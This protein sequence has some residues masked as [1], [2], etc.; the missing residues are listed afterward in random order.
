MLIVGDRGVILQVKSRDPSSDGDPEKLRRWAAKKTAEAGRQVLG[1]RRTLESTTLSLRS[2]RGHE[3]SLE[4]P[5]SWPGVILLDL[6]PVP[7]G[8]RV[9]GAD[10]NTIIMTLSDW[11]ALHDRIRSTSGV[12]DYIERVA[13]HNVEAD[14]GDEWTRYEQFAAADARHASEPGYVPVLP[15]KSLSGIDLL[16]VDIVD[17]WIDSDI[18]LT[19]VKKSPYTA[20]QVRSTIEL[21]DAIPILLRASIGKKLLGA[22]RESTRTREPQSGY[23][24]TGSNGRLLYFVDVID[25]WKGREQSLEL[26]LASYA[27]VRHEQLENLH[28]VGTTLMLARISTGG[29]SSIRTYAS[30]S[31]RAEGLNITPEV[32]W[33]TN[34]RYHVL[35]GDVLRDPLSYGRNEQCACGS[36]KRF[37]HCHLQQRQSSKASEYSNGAQ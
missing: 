9:S 28:G 5:H 32:R 12:I 22:V 14:L 21:L 11:Y 16:G 17:E 20:D 35:T 7:S 18:G 30:I 25:N 10:A 2:H 13:Q 37:K 15:M 34:I 31:G 33:G 26:D 8:L 6:D 19:P 1:T 36:G 27:A 4:P 3:L 23:L 24:S 29:A